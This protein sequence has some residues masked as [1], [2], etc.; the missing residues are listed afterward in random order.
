VSDEVQAFHTQWQD[1]AQKVRDD[2]HLCNN[3]T[4]FLAIVGP[5]ME[6]DLSEANI[7]AM[8]EN[9][10]EALDAATYEWR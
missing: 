7:K 6:N 10:G 9:M 8:F 2:G 5:V 3:P 4:E 1:L